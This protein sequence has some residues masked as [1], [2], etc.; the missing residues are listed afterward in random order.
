MLL[1]LATVLSDH[2]W[3]TLT[4]RLLILVMFSFLLYFSS[5]K[6]ISLFSCVASAHTIWCMIFNQEVCSRS[7]FALYLSSVCTLDE[8]YCS[9]RVYCLHCS[10]MHYYCK[11]C[12]HKSPSSSSSFP[13]P[14]LLFVDHHHHHRLQTTS[15]CYCKVI[16]EIKNGEGVE[17]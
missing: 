13:P 2:Y 9:I 6:N 1:Q 8:E 4:R 7:M 11:V 5:F 3:R 16:N 10:T 17:E 12:C 15:Y 14:P